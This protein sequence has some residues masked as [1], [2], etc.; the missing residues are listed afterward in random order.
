MYLLMH[1]LEEN[2]VVSRHFAV[3]QKLRRIA[4]GWS[5]EKPEPKK[6]RVKKVKA[7]DN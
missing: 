4:E 2:K 6:R 3:G 1:K 5:M 7:D